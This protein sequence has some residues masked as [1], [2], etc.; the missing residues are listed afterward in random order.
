MKLLPPNLQS[1]AEKI[2]GNIQFKK[3]NIIKKG[4]KPQLISCY[5]KK[6]YQS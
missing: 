5:K 6:I 4:A 1:L 3:S 2:R